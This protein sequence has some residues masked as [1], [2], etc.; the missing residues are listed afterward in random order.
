MKLILA[1]SLLS[2]TACTD[3]SSSSSGQDKGGPDALAGVTWHTT[4]SQNGFDFD[5]G[6]AFDD[7]K[8]TASN[9]CHSSG[10]SLTATTASQIKYRYSADIPKAGHGGDSSCFVD[11]LAGSFTFELAGDKLEVTVNGQTSEFTQGGG[12]RSGL[13]GDWT[14]MVNGFTVTWN[15]GGGKIHATAACPGGGS[16]S[17]TVNATFKNF[18]DI[19]E[20]QSMTVGDD[21]FNCTVSISKAMSEYYF[22]GND[23]V[24]VFNGQKQVFHR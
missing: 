17:A 12:S 5:F 23:L 7:T 19:L 16:A 2:V 11:V 6:F 21:S 24:I 14:A 20:D 3:D 9:T 18:V 8:V 13:Y 10:Q 4:I 22:Q 1:I 15:M